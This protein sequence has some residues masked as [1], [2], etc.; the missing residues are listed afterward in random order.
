[1][2]ASSLPSIIYTDPVLRNIRILWLNENELEELPAD[3]GHFQLLT[4]LRTFKNRLRQ[5]PPQIGDLAALQILW[6]CCL[7]S[8][9]G[10]KRSETLK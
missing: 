10:S 2:Q 7:L 9:R 1:M 6:R 8:C 4:Q 3:I 5:L